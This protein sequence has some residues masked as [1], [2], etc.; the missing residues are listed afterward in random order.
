MLDGEGEG[1]PLAMGK[2][3]LLEK[4]IGGTLSRS[5]RCVGQQLVPHVGL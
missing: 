3:V 5:L 4:Y 2:L 1:L